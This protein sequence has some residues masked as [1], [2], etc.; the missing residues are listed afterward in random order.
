MNKR[1]PFLLLVAFFLLF[2]LTIL[3]MALAASFDPHRNWKTIKTDHFFVRYPEEIEPVAQDV[4][5]ILEEVNAKLSPE[6]NW[7][8][9]GKTEVV[10]T[11]S[12][13]DA[14]GMTTL[15]PYNWMILY[16][17][18]PRPDSSLA[19][20]D[21]WL[22]T[23][24]VHEYTHLLTIDPARGFWKPFRMIFGKTVSPYGVTPGWAREG[25]AVY[26]ESAET[27][28][29]RNRSSYSE[30]LLRSAVLED[31]FPTIDEADGLGWRW[32]SY[33]TAY[34]FGGK[35]IKYLVDTYGEDKF[36]EFNRRI[37]SSPLLSM[38]NHQAR[39]V[40]HK[41]FYQLW[42]EWRE[43][44]D[45]KYEDIAAG[46]KEQGLTQ[47]EKI[48][49]PTWDEQF[50]AAVPSPDGKKLAYV[51]SS[52]HRKTEIRVKDL[53]TGKVE[54]VA[55]RN[56]NQIA[57]SPDGEKIA[58]SAESSYKSYNLYF[59]LW[60]Y[61]LAEKKAKKLTNGLRARD[62][63]FDPAGKEIVFVAGSAGTDAIKRINLETKEIIE[64]TAPE[65]RNIHLA[66]P[67][68][69]P[70]GL[71]IACDV[72]ET[73]EG[74]K[75]KLYTLSGSWH[76]RLTNGTGMETSP[77]WSPDGNYIFYSSDESG[78]PN[79]YRADAKS[80]TSVKVSNVLT[81]VF[82]PVTRD[83]T[84]VYVR[85]Y[86]SKG[87][88]ISSFDAPLTREEWDRKQKSKKGKK[89][90]I[91][92]AEK[93]APPMVPA[94][95]PMEPEPYDT[96]KY[97]PFGKSLFLPRVL[98]P[99][100]A[101]LQDAFFFSLMTGGTDVL[102][103][104]SW[105]AG[106]TYR[107]DSKHF[108][109][110]GRY[111]YSRWRPVM[112]VGIND[113]SVDMGDLTFVFPDGLTNTVHYYEERR[114]LNAFLTIPIKNHSFSAS[115]FYEDRMP[116]TSLTQPEKDALN[117]GIFAGFMGNYTYSDAE[118]YPASISPENGRTIR[119]TGL[120]T[121][122]IFGGGERN[123]QIIFAGDWREYIRLWHHHVLAL[124][125]AGGIQWG[126]RQVQ[127]TFGLGGALGEG[128]F[129]GGYSYNYFPLRGLPVSALSR[130]RAM[131]MSAEYRLP[132]VAAQR[133]I[134]TWPFYL[135]N[136]YAAFFADYGNAWNA[137]QNEGS[138]INFFDDFMLGVG[139]EMR[140]DF[141][142][143]H[144]LPLTARLGY[145]IIVVNRDRI[146][147]LTDP[148]LGTS[149]DWGTLILQFGTSF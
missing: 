115:Y 139:T 55:K 20:Y 46:V 105:I 87:F 7:K 97:S 145:G 71:T 3:Q 127:G 114:N 112:G 89:E 125:S 146:G 17:V 35:F 128:S 92:K 70:D 108:G 36:L 12:T 58:Y 93:E 99:N 15:I 96:M 2:S 48:V 90:K 24:I 27:T 122:S 120:T 95:P 59:D 49:T 103:R 141:I 80:G 9:W 113:Y 124:R 82:E 30:M 98:F 144:G 101:Y 76:K 138:G 75:I 37:Q 100:I 131:L 29:G 41:T 69:S 111:A 123:E 104:H 33:N 40:Y 43:G 73:G 5:R 56:A 134:G 44:L 86:N 110:F 11:D 133:G 63:D 39:N 64:I 84:K 4:A 143:G 126:D 6:F 137:D 85:E 118:M 81:G 47:T 66:D 94:P 106:G 148:I 136:F 31:N 77:W 32:P 8:P 19:N 34:I 10:L 116:E 147:T 130:T 140:G 132:I 45:V 25:V 65:P 91:S 57:W 83:G 107:T 50:S 117:L 60:L 79:V 67:K 61:D 62:P 14:N 142:I 121:N 23:L 119:L 78:I 42:R 26:E 68:F 16:V 21:N 88:V 109:Y 54:I 53:E 18:P 38:V 135:K 28:A 72:W 52:P 22:R 13:D 51:A 1:G 74:W 149:L 129:G 102:R